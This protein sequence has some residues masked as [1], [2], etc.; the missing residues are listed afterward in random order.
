MWLAQCYPHNVIQAP[1]YTIWA[2][3]YD[4]HDLTQTIWPTRFDPLNLTRKTW[5]TQLDALN[6]KFN[7]LS[8]I[9]LVKPTQLNS[10]GQVTILIY[11]GSFSGLQVNAEW[12]VNLV[13]MW[14]TDFWS[15]TNW[16]TSFEVMRWKMLDMKSTMMANVL[17]F[18]RH[19][20]IVTPW[21]TKE[22][23]L[24]FTAN[25]PKA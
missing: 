17:Q 3:Q 8:F 5:P 22:P 6:L 12:V 13:R 14:P 24:T 15:I 19:P 9:H 4:P 2:T 18:F 11:N 16:T 21:E 1:W 25:L 20:I 10:V 7:P 23:L